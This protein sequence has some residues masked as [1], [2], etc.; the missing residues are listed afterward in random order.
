[1]N[2]VAKYLQGHLAGKVSTRRDVLDHYA[3]T[4]SVLTRRPDFV[5]EPRNTNDVRK[6]TRF[7]WQLAE[8]GHS[9]GL[10]VRGLGGDPTGGSMGEGIIIDTSTHMTQI[11]EYDSKQH[12]L[13]AQPGAHLDAVQAALSL[14][15]SRLA[16][17]LSHPKGTLGGALGYGEDDPLAGKS[18]IDRLEVVLDNGDVL[19][20]GVISKREF[21]KRQGAQT[22]EGD[23]YRGISAVLEDYDELIKTMRDSETRD[24]SGYM[25]I[26][27]VQQRGGGVDLTPLFVGSQGTLGIVTEMIVRSEYAPSERV[28]GAALFGSPEAALDAVD[29]VQKLAPTTLEYIDGPLI[30]ESLVQGNNYKWMGDD[31]DPSAVATDAVLLIA[32]FDAFKDRR[33]SHIIKK[34]K[35]KL[36][37]FDCIFTTSDETDIHALVTLLDYSIH[38]PTTH[39]HGSPTLA[40]SFYVPYN[41]LED[42]RNGLLKLGEKLQLELPLYGELVVGNY[43][44][45]PT[46]NLHKVGDKQKLLKIIDGLNALVDSYDGSLVA[47]GGEGRLLSRFVRS[48]WDEQVENMMNDIKKIFDP[49]NILNPGVKA[50]VELKELVKELRSD[51]KAY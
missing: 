41:R 25:G 26:L 19:Q 48:T 31:L 44:I 18:W 47:Y 5:I 3:S 35:K 11:Y 49:Y 28:Y 16:L 32:G 6:V 10:T 29:A 2:K 20:T 4:A 9:I 43:R 50:D 40:P 8:K 45:M 24:M 15:R 36:S 23:I 12:L 30:A 33:R 38:P 7:A 39:E 14:N 42:F 17:E 22:R 27:D 21:N 13:R 46:L 37:S 34:L 1:M 51:N